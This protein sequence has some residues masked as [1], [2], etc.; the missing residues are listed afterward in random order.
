MYVEHNNSEV[1]AQA[2]LEKVGQGLYQN[3][4]ENITSH[5]M[6][7]HARSRV[8]VRFSHHGIQQRSSI[9]GGR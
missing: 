5:T 8:P 7:R 2:A 9:F 3:I 4:T 1:A 6:F